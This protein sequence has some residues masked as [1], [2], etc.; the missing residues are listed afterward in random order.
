MSGV[1]GTGVG[2]SPTLNKQLEGYMPTIID[3]DKVKEMM[4]ELS[5]ENREVFADMLLQFSHEQ[6][7]NIIKRFVDD[8]D[9]ESLIYKIIINLVAEFICKAMN[10]L[11][12]DVRIQDKD[13]Y[14][15]SD[16][17]IVIIKILQSM[18]TNIE[19]EAPRNIAI[20]LDS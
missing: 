3:N 17:A 6:H 18:I 19:N 15:G 12:D 10:N 1:Q 8:F 13:S 14:E 9:C 4:S 2:E 7:L 5:P 20:K 11:N 16:A